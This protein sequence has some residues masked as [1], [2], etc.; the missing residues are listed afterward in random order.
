MVLREMI[1]LAEQLYHPDTFSAILYKTIQ[2]INPAVGGLELYEFRYGLNNLIPQQ[3]WASVKLDPLEMIEQSVN[4]RTFYDHIQIKPKVD[5]RI[6]LDGNIL[7]LTRTLMVG[8]VTGDYP[9]EW[10]RA[11]FYF[12][13]RGFYFL[14]RTAYFSAEILTRFGGAPFRQF[15]KRQKQFVWNQDLGYQDFKAANAEVDE[16]F[17]ECV[18]KLITSRG[19]PI[20]IAIAGPTAAGKTEI[21]GRLQEALERSGRK[22]TSIELD[23]FLTD[24]DYREAHGIF[25]QGKEALHFELF[26][27]C[28]RALCQGQKI[29]IPRYDFVFATSS[30]DLQGNLKP[31]GVPIEIEPADVIF[32]EGNFPFL[33]EETVH[34]I[35]IKV[36]YLTDDEIRLKR[37]WKRDIDYRK[38]YEP[39]YFRNRYFKD[40][41]IMAEIAYRPQMEVCDLLVDTTGAALWVSS[42]L[43]GALCP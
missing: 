14:H 1:M 16:F 39:T 3:G 28:L 12:D 43:S 32:I 25:T 38:K 9:V 15:E 41:F 18:Q 19:T 31:G 33:I 17:I 27:G 34:L 5:D 6:V 2:L 4:D 30:H 40:Q 22:T 11:H 13:I 20:V 35:D 8:L 42:E 29:T 37:K 24:R 7:H 23:N 26:K 10:V 21:V 36:V